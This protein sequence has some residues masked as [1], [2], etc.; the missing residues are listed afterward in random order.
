MFFLGRYWFES[1]D[2]NL[3][4]LGLLLLFWNLVCLLLDNQL[5][6]FFLCFCF[7]YLLLLFSIL[8]FH[9]RL[10]L[11]FVVLDLWV[12]FLLC[13]S[14]QYKILCFLNWYFLCFL[15]FMLAL[16]VRLCLMGRCCRIIFEFGVSMISLRL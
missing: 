6:G 4:Y 1:F 7:L 9:V 16:F 14:F 5:I 11:S 15:G 10:L 2:Y 8:R 3:P 13:R 12:S